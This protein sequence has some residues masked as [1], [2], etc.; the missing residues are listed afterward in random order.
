QKAMAKSAAGRYATAAELAADLG[1]FL[2][3]QSILA[4]RPSLA[5]RSAKWVRRHRGLV[6]GLAGA[7]VLLAVAPACAGWYHT[8]Q[9]RGT[10]KALQ[11]AVAKAE[12]ESEEATRQRRMSDR[13][14]VV[15]QLRLTQQAIDKRQF[16]F[17]Q[18]LL[19]GIASG[20][21]AGKTRE[22]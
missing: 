6:T 9:L 22:F 10:N 20:L 1:R 2:D 12:A 13:H 3:D 17:A 5:D 18:D 16:E 15:E 21:S 11:D 4:R 19:D 14:R 8:T 7:L